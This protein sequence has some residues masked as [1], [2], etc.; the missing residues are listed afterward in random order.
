M[1]LRHRCAVL[2]LWFLPPA[3]REANPDV[4][5]RA[6]LC[7][8]YNLTVP[9][10]GPGFAVLL[11]ALGQPTIAA[12]IAVGVV[13]APAP[14]F[15]VRQTGSL[16]LAGNAMAALGAFLIVSCTWLEGGLGAPGVMWFPMIPIL[17]V[18]VAGRRSGIV[19]TVILVGALV[20]FHVLARSGMRVAFSLH[21]AQLD[22]LHLMLAASAVACMLALAI[23]FE[24]L[25]AEAMRS[26]EEAN[27]A[28]ALARDEAEAA[29]RAK[30]DFLANMS[31]EIRTPIHGIFGMTEMAL[32]TA[33]DDER[34]HCIERARACAETLLA[35]IN[36][37]LDF[38]RVEAGKLA[39]EATEVDVRAVVDGVL[40]T[41]AVEA[42]RKGLELIGC[43]DDWVPARVV[44]DPGRLRQVLVNLAGNAV[45]FTDHGEVV[46]RLALEPDPT[47]PPG[48]LLL[49]GTVCDTGIG[50]PRAQQA[51]IFDAFTQAD[52]SMSRRYGG[53]GLGLA[54]TQRLVTLMGGSVNLE[55]EPGAGSTFGFT[56]RLGAATP[57]STPAV[58]LPPGLRVLV[59]ERSAASRRHLL[60]TLVG[61]GCEVATA[62]DEEEAW[63]LLTAR[64]PE[65]L[66]VD[67]AMPEPERLDHL[68]RAAGADAAI[69][70]LLPGIGGAAGLA[71]SGEVAAIV[72]RPIKSGDLFAAMA[73]AA[74]RGAATAAVP[75]AA[76]V[77]A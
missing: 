45:K 7:V 52:S 58:G 68:R 51:L 43:V 57:S 38:S 49:R 72:T 46:I 27:R 62:V 24:S 22:F 76:A 74:R 17:A 41:L 33:E 63:V 18:L 25:K 48:T 61:W 56:A 31:H 77:G 44:G 21:G 60:H 1:R 23:L 37:V 12:I 53:A 19:W 73:A 32:D 28:F 20:T 11:W 71:R 16:V 35:V 39:L 4:V 75:R 30:S 5:R 54:I 34:R 6:K 55:S 50:I 36:D 2:V 3:L 66:I 26:L 29:T 70:A 64:P 8:A 13:L 67:L 59:V 9:L 47:G 65:V 69:V 10:W 40:D 14:L 15:V 42:G